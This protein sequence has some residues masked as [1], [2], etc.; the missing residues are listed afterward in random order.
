MRLNTA[1]NEGGRTDDFTGF[2]PNE[3]RMPQITADVVSPRFPCC[4]ERISESLFVIFE[5]LREIVAILVRRNA[6]QCS[7]E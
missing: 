5:L 1:E 2:P 7:I 3:K 6:T 4:P